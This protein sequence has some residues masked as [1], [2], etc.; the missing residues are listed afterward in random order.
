MPDP[1]DTSK[2]QRTKKILW[3]STLNAPIRGA[4]NLMN[5]SY[6][7]LVAGDAATT[8]RLA[9]DSLSAAGAATAGGVMSPKPRN[10]IGAGGGR[11]PKRL[12]APKAAPKSSVSPAAREGSAAKKSVSPAAREPGELKAGPAKFRKKMETW[13]QEGAAARNASPKKRS[14]TFADRVD[15]A[16]KSAASGPPNRATRKPRPGESKFIGPTR[17]PVPGDK[18]FIGPRQPP[19]AGDRDFV[20]PVRPQ[21]TAGRK[22]RPGEAK[23]IGPTRPP[24]PGDK[25]FIGPRQPPRAGDRDFIGPRQPPRAGDKNFIGPVKTFRNKGGDKG[26]RYT[27]AKSA[28]ALAGL[29]G[30]GYL[31]WQGAPT[32]KAQKD[33]GKVQKPRTG[34]DVP[35]S[36]VDAER[37]KKAD[38]YRKKGQETYAKLRETSK[39]KKQAG[40]KSRVAKPVKKMT[41]FERMKMR[42]Y[43]KEGVAGRSVSSK[44]AK[45]RVMKERSY[46]F[47][48][49]FK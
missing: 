10:S 9:G 18:N 6:D 29:G 26:G 35:R 5:A 48:D 17:P 42:Q 31:T 40:D 16:K 43:E 34:G 20:G 49:F 45:A 19:R 32:S 1:K 24:V 2:W 23:F 37:K 47:S 14:G 36:T 39:D 13:R 25:N 22:P 15:A 12:E 30:A 28:A 7:D 27:G 46:K 4:Y 11:G 21:K 3:D 38:A 41:N 8:E 33:A 44:R